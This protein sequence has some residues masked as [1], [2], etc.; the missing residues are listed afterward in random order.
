M[1][2]KELKGQSGENLAQTLGE[3]EKH[4][5]QLR[6]QSATDRLETP[7]EIGKAK[8]DI[9]RLK[10]EQRRREL[11]ADAKLTP[12]AAAQRVADLEPKAD[13][14]GK[15]RI[16]RAIARL[17]PLTANAPAVPVLATTT[18][19]PAAAPTAGV[20]PAKKGK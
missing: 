4:L 6:F 20:A 11:E 19:P 1:K 3:T 16:R 15:R 10:T 18:T 14:P 17:G 8:R 12:A 7:S 9:A 2:A 13:G 5:F